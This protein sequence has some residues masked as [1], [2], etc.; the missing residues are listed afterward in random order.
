[1][2]P[3]TLEDLPPACLD[4]VREHLAAVRHDLGKYVVF[5][6]RWLA[7][8]PSDAELREALLAD[9]GRTRCRG[10]QVEAAPTLWARLRQPLVGASVLPGGA[11]IDLSADPD[12]VAI[13]GEIAEIA[14]ILPLL[15]LAPR[16][17]LERAQRAAQDV[18]AA[19]RRLLQ[20]ARAL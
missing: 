15:P 2:S 19:T 16:G 6:Q 20:R 9:L 18:S 8:Q 3:I 1:M 14:E 17:E 7:G 4:D 11:V 5:Q 13:D 10:E 12:L